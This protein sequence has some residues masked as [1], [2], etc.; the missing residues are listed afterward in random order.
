MLFTCQNYLF[1]T[2]TYFSITEGKKEEKKKKKSIICLL[3]VPSG[4]YKYQG[5]TGG[6]EMCFN[7]A[8]AGHP[9]KCG[10]T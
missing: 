9:L 8:S 1:G 7:V 10:R 4:T 2:S 6:G 5:V 3:Q